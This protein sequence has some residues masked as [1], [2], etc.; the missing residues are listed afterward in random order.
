MERSDRP[1]AVITGASSG[2][3]KSA[4]RMLAQSGWHVI[5]H[6]RDPARSD[7]ALAELRAAAAPEARVDMVRCDLSLLSETAVMA[8]EIA[9]L[10]DRLDVLINNA[11]GV[12]D[13]MEIT[14]EGN[15]I[16]FAGNH[17]GHFLLTKRM[18]PLLKATAATS[19]P[20]SVR[21]LATSSE[22]HR[23]AP[24][25][26]WNDLQRVENWVTGTNYCLA[27][28]CNVLFTHELARRFGP[29][30][31]V[32]NTIHPGEAKTNFA[33]HAEP[34]M[35]KMIQDQNE[36]SPDVGG[37]TLAWL[38]EAPETGRITG[39]YFYEREQFE[40]GDAA[41]DGETARRLWDESEKLLA[42]SGF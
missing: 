20:G 37:D 14:P 33:S 12:R 8:D 27:K 4:A 30:G 13:R 24:P 26:D 38:A 28:L 29:L 23:V 42:R 35:A 3:G 39:G 10:T 21:I 5:A 9:G 22:G 2:V 6:G 11:G 31:I 17:L 19:E 34:W 40:L 36:V 15:E 41:T 18:M 32:A 16:T 25:F 7:A 1:C